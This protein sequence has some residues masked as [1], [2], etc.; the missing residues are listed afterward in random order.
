MLTAYRVHLNDGSNYVTSMAKD[1][2]L[3]MAR[4]YFIGQW[5][6]QSD[7]KTMLQAV[8]VTPESEE[9]PCVTK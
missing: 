6:E 9:R 8:N 4:A 3:E 5:F 1:I 2:T 7:E